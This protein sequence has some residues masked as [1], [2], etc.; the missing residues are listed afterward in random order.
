MGS[1]RARPKVG[2]RARVPDVEQ[3]TWVAEVV[4]VNLDVQAHTSRVRMSGYELRE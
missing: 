4:A 1:P 2:G 3:V